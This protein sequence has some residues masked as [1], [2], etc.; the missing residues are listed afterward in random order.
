[1]I[2]VV[3]AQ[4][5]EPLAFWKSFSELNSCHSCHCGFQTSP[6]RTSRT[7]A[8]CVAKKKAL[9]HTYALSMVNSTRVG[10]TTEENF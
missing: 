6:I 1:M 9:E 8:F 5:K 2:H 7:S 10:W 3:L 4:N